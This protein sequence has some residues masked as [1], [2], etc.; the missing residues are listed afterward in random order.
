MT[1]KVQND[2]NQIIDFI[3]EHKTHG[4]NMNIA[5]KCKVSYAIV[6]KTLSKEVASGAVSD[7]VIKCFLKV[8][9][10]RQKKYQQLKK[11]L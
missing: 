10:E 4:D 2:R 6:S 3:K 11:S 8:I 1:L 9:K 5:K 7:K